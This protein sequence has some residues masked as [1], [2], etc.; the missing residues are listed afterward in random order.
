L[1]VLPLMLENESFLAGILGG[2]NVVTHTHQ[3]KQG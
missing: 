3:L 1:P 2:K